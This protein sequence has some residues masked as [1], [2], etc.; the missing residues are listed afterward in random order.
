MVNMLHQQTKVTVS[1]LATFIEADVNRK[2]L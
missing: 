1:G 2:F